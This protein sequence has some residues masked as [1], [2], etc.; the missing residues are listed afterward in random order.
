MMR[1]IHRLLFSMALVLMLFGLAGAQGA[2]YTVQ[3]A[4]VPTREE[5]DAKLQELKAKNVIA[6]IVKSV[7][8]G[9]GVFY[10]VRAGIFSNQ[11]DAK[12]FGAGLQ[13]RGVVSEYFITAYEK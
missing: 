6:Y 1:F 7:V 9:K 13:Q 5:A 11:N 2:G 12:K 3:F 4:A 10:R 8:P